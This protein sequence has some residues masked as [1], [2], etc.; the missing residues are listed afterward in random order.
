MH[1][2]KFKILTPEKSLFDKEVVSVALPTL[3]GE[4]TILAKHSPLISVMT[5]GEVRVKYIN[6]N[7]KEEEIRFDL[8]GGVLEVRD[9]DGGVVLVSD[10][11]IDS[12]SVNLEDLEKE[13]ERA[14]EAMKEKI[15]ENAFAEMESGLERSVYL[16][17]IL[18]RKK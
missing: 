15:D 3:E 7:K 2:F 14:K 10:T 9:H 13:I 4:L 17:K 16:R 18:S 1:T 5:I 8:Q 6:D 12:D 11:Q